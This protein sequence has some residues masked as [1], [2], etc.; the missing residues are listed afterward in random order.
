M[1]G[2]T[3]VTPTSNVKGP[4]ERDFVDKMGYVVPASNVSVEVLVE[5]QPG[6]LG[7]Y[8]TEK[9]IIR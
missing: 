8:P 2:R 7:A 3:P 1:Q 5:C 6:N 9:Q 4:I